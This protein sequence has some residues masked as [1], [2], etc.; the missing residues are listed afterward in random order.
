MEGYKKSVKTF[1]L[2]IPDLYRA[3]EG[4]K[5]SEHVD[6]SQQVNICGTRC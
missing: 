1:R 3:M 6:M 4:R 2:W 5:K